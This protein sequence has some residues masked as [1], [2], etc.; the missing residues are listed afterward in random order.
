MVVKLWS[1]VKLLRSKVLLVYRNWYVYALK[2]IMYKQRRQL[3]NRARSM[4]QLAN[5]RQLLT[6][7]FYNC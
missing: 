5:V 2:I 1:E 6:D 4:G 3:M 7:Y